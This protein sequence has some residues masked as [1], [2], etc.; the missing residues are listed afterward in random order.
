MF[1]RLQL[2]SIAIL[3]GL[4]A[5]PTFGQNTLYLHDFNG[6]PGVP[7]HG[8][9]PDINN[10]GSTDTWV[11]R[12]DTGQVT[13]IGQLFF[14][15]GTINGSSGGVN[16]SATLAFIPQSGFTYTLTA[17]FNAVTSTGNNWVALGFT[18]GQS[19]AGSNN[20]GRFIGPGGTAGQPWM[21]YRG[22]GA[23]QA[24]QTFLGPGTGLPAVDWS[25]PVTASHGAPVDLRIILNTSNSIWSAQ[26]QAKNPADATFTTIRN[27]VYATNPNIGG[28]GIAI[29]NTDIMT[30]INSFRL[31]TSGTI[32]TPGDA[33]GDGL[34]NLLDF[35]SISDNLFNTPATRPQG[36][37]DGNTLVDFN[38]FRVW[39]SLATGSGAGASPSVPEPAAGMI[40]NLALVCF[41]CAR[42]RGQR[43]AN[44]NG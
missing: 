37:L 25:T 28:V 39:K 13:G 17:S 5:I 15:D 33:N 36:D 27:D 10:T 41:L 14:A 4:A 35:N 26:W 16:G 31:E 24:D 44:S 23:S 34:V 30:R 20:P 12:T 22:T 32:L 7:L 21:I 43:P 29:A 8:A 3:I 40:A 6:G 1:P 18:E 19:S 9:A 38:D 42:R 2:I 11:T